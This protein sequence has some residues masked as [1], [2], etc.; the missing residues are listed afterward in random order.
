MCRNGVVGVVVY[1]GEIKMLAISHCFDIMVAHPL[2]SEAFVV[3]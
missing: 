1:K 2:L 3:G